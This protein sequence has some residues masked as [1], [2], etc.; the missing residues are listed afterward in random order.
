LA[1]GMWMV[2]KVMLKPMP[3]QIGLKGGETD[4]ELLSLKPKDF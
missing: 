4:F 2:P 3:K 1:G